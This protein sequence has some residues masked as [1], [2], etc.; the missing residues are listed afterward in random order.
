[1]NESRRFLILKERRREALML[2]AFAA[3]AILLV[4][5]AGNLSGAP[6]GGET[7]SAESIADSSAPPS[8]S[9][10][11]QA[12]ENKTIS[13]DPRTVP[14]APDLSFWTVDEE[15]WLFTTSDGQNYSSVWETVDGQMYYFKENGRFASGWTVIDGA[16][17]QFD[18][19]GRMYKDMWSSSPDG[20]LYRLSS[21]GAAVTGWYTES[22]GRVFYMAS[23]GSVQYGWQDIDGSRYYLGG[24]GVLITGYREIDGNHYYFTESGKMHTGWADLDDGRHYFYSDGTMAVGL[25]TLDDTLYAFSVDGVL[26]HGM[27]TFNGKLYYFGEDGKV[28]TGWVTAEDGKHYFDAPGSQYIGW[29]YYNGG[30]HFFTQSGVLDESKKYTDSPAVAITFD[31]GPGEYTNAI[32]DLLDSYHV[33]ATFFML[34]TE[35]EKYPEAVKREFDLGMEQGNHTWDHTTL[36]KLTA[37]EI[38]KEITKT[39]DTIKAIT[40]KAPTLFRPPGGGT[41]ATVEASSQGMPLITWNVDTR[42]WETRDAGSTYNIVMNEVSDGDIILMH[43]IYQASYEAAQMIIPDLLRRGYQLVTVS[44]LAKL[45]NTELKGGQVYSNFN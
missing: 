37:P 34:G 7:S 27:Q 45:K 20:K 41:N 35:V 14:K 31:D 36:T 10:L 28:V 26:L 19:A 32:L 6:P 21:G 4:Y 24:D 33:K 12:E 23:D 44:E 43:E 5:C 17:Y 38:A 11:P 25:V 2:I 30:W 13:I 18:P 16:T 3:A 8:D 29:H 9:S 40:G 15:G 39:N 22:D 1:M 42:D